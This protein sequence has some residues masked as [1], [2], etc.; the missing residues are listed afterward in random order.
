[1][2]YFDKNNSLIKDGNTLIHSSGESRKVTLAG[3]L[4]TIGLI[5]LTVNYSRHLIAYGDLRWGLL[6]STLFVAI[7][8]AKQFTQMVGHK[9]HL[10]PYYP[11]RAS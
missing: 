6:F 5:P 9:N 8:D 10:W 11:R 2:N 7:K 4:K 1:M 3:D